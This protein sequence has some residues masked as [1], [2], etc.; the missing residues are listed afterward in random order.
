MTAAGQLALFGL[1]P[2]DIQWL[3]MTHTDIDHVG[4]IADFP[5]AVMVI[6]Q[7][8][9]A[10]DSPRYFADRSP[11][12]W[13]ADVTYQLIREDTDLCPG[14]T[15]FPAPGHAVNFH[16]SF[17]CPVLAPYCSRETPFPDQQK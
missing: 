9:R 6:G 16:C 17:A 4:G 13:P 10:L 11:V 12:S 7:A 2:A 8:E 5:Q 1:K 15:L 14:V 3:V